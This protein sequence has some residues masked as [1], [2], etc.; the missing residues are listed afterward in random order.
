[1]IPLL[2]GT[3]MVSLG[4]RSRNGGVVYDWREQEA[5]FEV[6][7]PGRSTGSVALDLGVDIRSA[8]LS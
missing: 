7:N 5:R 2:D 8:D 3:Y 4:L 6:L 1:H